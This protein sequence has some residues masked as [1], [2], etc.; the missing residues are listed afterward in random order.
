M[1]RVGKRFREALDYAAALHEHQ[2]R[3]RSGDDL[4]WIPYVAHLLGVASLVLEVDGTEDEAIAGLLH[5][6]LEDHPRE[7]RTAREIEE[8]FGEAVLGIVRHCTKPEVD[9]T[10][11]EE[12]VRDR[13]RVQTARYVEHLASAPT[14][15]K[16]VAAADKL[17][18]ARSIVSDLREH[19]DRVWERFRK[20]REEAVRYYEDLAAALRRGDPRSERL[21]DEL[22]R[23]VKVMR[24]LGSPSA[25]S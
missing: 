13:L 18:N 15:A 25:D 7:G 5:D 6:A 3:K 9:E 20:T 24:A 22:V 1:A 11:S 17:H 16:L 19:G 10:G 2:P 12:A 8:R 23:T 4:P 21:V 14:P